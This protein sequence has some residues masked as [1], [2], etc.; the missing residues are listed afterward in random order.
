M[1]ALKTFRN[2]LKGL[3]DLLNYAAETEDGIILGK[4]GSLMA[5]WVYSGEDQS[6]HMPAQR[7]ALT[8]QINAALATLGSGWMT[9]HDCI[10]TPTAAYPGISESH[11]PEAISRLIDEERRQ[12][13]E[14]GQYFES[15]HVLLVTFLPATTSKSKMRDYIYEED[16]KRVKGSAT[17]ELDNFQKALLELEDRLGAIIN[18]DRLCGHEYEDEG[19]E[20]HIKDD[21][22]SYVQWSVTGIRQQVNL[23]VVPMY[24]DAVIGCQELIPGIAPKVGEHHIRL[25]AIDGYPQESYPGILEALDQV[26]I[27]YRWSTRFI[28]LDAFE[29]EKE[30]EKYRKVWEQKE[31]S[32]K[33]QMFNVQSGKIDLDAKEM[34]SDATRAKAEANSGYVRYGYYTSVIV[35]MD[36]HVERANESARAVAQIIRNLGFSARLETINA[37]E[38]WLGT[39]P[40]HG[41]QNV[42]RPLMHTLNLAHLLPLS[43]VWAGEKTNSCPFY[44]PNS[45]PLLIGATD[46][47]T[48]WRF[49]LHVNDIGHTL[50]LGPTGS[51]KSTKLVFLMAQFLRY[52]NAS[53]YAFDKG[54]SAYVLTKAVGGQHYDLAGDSGDIAFAPLSVLDTDR[55]M[56]WA[57]QWVETVVELQGLI[58]QPEHRREIHRALKLLKKSPHRTL[59]AYHAT[60]QKQDL[61]DALEPYTLDG[62]FG[63]LFD[64]EEDSLK[65][66]RF[67]VFEVEHLMNMGERAVLPALDYIFYRI[68][69]QLNGQPAMIPL[70]E[71]W[72]MLSNPVFKE[73]IRE[74]LKVLRKRNCLVIMATQ[75]LSDVSRSGLLDVINETCMTKIF[76]ANPQAVEDEAQELYRRLGLNRTQIG[77]IS[78]MTPK[79]DYY[80]TSPLGKR[81][82]RLDLGPVALAFAG[83]SGKDDIAHAKQVMEQ[84]EGWQFAWLRQKGVQL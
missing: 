6:S 74:W 75:S 14:Q 45:P 55:D 38:A 69:K 53:V 61:K 34:T 25:V 43:S 9:H 42:R 49:N 82:Y 65:D 12:L 46:G 77:I 83:V 40:S 29:A 32:L 8:A 50:M 4:D 23:P 84:G 7:N 26:A 28:Y 27:S 17:T 56:S 64:A 37:V 3:P 68:E 1:L 31:R 71:A 21:L 63:N 47:S 19:G 70:D 73:K 11:F 36:E 5:G 67:Q 30:L 35:L 51:G 16:G 80:Y 15:L 33:D 78:T 72:I 58:L 13:F 2:K 41:V 52:A 81:K 62:S 60:L 57:T 39:L 44:P 79:R 48:P 18:L 54:Y 22:L 76:L 10:R 20:K 66:G 24:L 59:T